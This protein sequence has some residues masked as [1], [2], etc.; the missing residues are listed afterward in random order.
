M[1]TRST[2]ELR[3]EVNQLLHRQR[4][5]L[6]TRMLGAATEAE[7]LEYEVRQEIIHELCNELVHSLSAY[8]S[9]H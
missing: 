5:V 9:F 1:N 8:R 3:S 6:E 2:E 4:E 7:L